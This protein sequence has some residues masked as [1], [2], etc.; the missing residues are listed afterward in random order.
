METAGDLTELTALM[1]SVNAE[2][3]SKKTRIDATKQEERKATKKEL[4]ADSGKLSSVCVALWF[5]VLL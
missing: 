4:F 1:E 2:L 3:G 5:T